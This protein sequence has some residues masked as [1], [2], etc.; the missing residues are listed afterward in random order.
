MTYSDSHCHL[1]GYEPERLATV[2]DQARSKQVDIIVSMG[3]D[4]ESSAATIGLAGSHPE[5]LAAVGIHPWNAVPPTRELCTRLRELA[6]AE[7]VVALGEIGLDYA[8]SPE[9]KEA[10]KELLTYELSL[11]RQLGLPVNIHCREAHEDMMEILRGDI[12]SV[13]NQ[14]QVAIVAIVGAGMR[15]HPGI[16]SQVFRALAEE[17][18]NIISIAQGSSEYNLSLVLTHEDVN[19]GV[20]S[21]HQQFGL[22]NGSARHLEGA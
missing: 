14:D 9:T 10:Q 3:M 5:V 16:A 6:G 11:A 13:I 1:D 8:R 18:I 17:D 15:G 22:D 4:L 7:G 19:G 21:I 2:L 20:R 12:D